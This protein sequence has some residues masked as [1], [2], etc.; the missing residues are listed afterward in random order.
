[1]WY[2]YIIWVLTHAMHALRI[3]NEWY[4]AKFGRKLNL[5]VWS[6]VIATQFQQHA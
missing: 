6:S 2:A 1:M 4:I 3:K 5:V